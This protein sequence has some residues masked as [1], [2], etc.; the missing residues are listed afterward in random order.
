MAK[1]DYYTEV[2]QRIRL[3]LDR[4]SPRLRLSV[5]A[6]LTEAGVVPGEDE[7]RW[8]NLIDR[9]VNYVGEDIDD[10]AT[11]VLETIDDDEDEEESPTQDAYDIFKK[12]SDG[13]L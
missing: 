3:E 10:F 9:L 6:Y 12:G 13:Y 8:F 1:K 11:M 7:D 5:I 2:V 4:R